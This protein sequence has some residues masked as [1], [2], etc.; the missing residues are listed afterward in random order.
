MFICVRD[1]VLGSIYRL[2]ESYNSHN[3]K[4]LVETQ[5]PDNT[6][7]AVPSSLLASLIIIIAVLIRSFSSKDLKIR[8]SKIRNSVF[9]G[10]E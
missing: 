5:S 4:I 3:F 6:N 9:G 10:V 2:R 8:N 7:T 1:K